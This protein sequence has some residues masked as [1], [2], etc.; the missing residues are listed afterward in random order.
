MA[1]DAE[2]ARLDGSSRATRWTAAA[3]AFGAMRMAYPQAYAL[4]RS[5]E[6]LLAGSHA[7]SAAAGPLRQ[8]YAIAL[9]LEAAP[10][11]SEIEALAKR[12]RVDLN[13]SSAPAPAPPSP[14]QSAGLTSRER[15]VLGLV[16][17]GLTNRQIAE[18][19]FITE[20]TAGVHVSNILAKLGV[21][22]RTEA[23]AVA[24]RLDLER[25]T[26][27]GQRTSDSSRP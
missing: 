3:E 18:A 24:H 22:G 2:F 8:A 23:A 16:A 20:G 6:S 1:G 19:L 14:L 7:R 9:E 21:R 5:A 12:G 27:A 10:L 4:W 25:P 26:A 15:E 11:R 17:S 13:P